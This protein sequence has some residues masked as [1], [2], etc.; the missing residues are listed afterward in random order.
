MYK[1]TIVFVLLI[2]FCVT[3][4]VSAQGNDSTQVYLQKAGKALFDK[5]YQ[6]ALTNYQNVL[7]FTP[8]HFE[9]I[10]NLGI[11]YSA[12]GD[13][14]KAREYFERAYQMDESD[15]FV[16]NNLGVLYSNE[17]NINKA[18]EYYE[19]AVSLLPNN[20]LY[21][22]NYAQ[23][24]TKIGQNGKAIELLLKA[25]SLS[26]DNLVTLF[27]L[28]NAYASSK[29]YSRA[30]F[31][32]EKSLT[33]GL[34]S[35]KLYYFLATVKRNLGKENETEAYLLKTIELDSE[36]TNALIGLGFLYMHQKK[37]SKAV[38][39]FDRVLSIDPN[40]INAKI[41]KGVALQMLKDFEKSDAVLKELFAID[42][43]YGFKMLEIIRLQHSQKEK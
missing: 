16:N 9:T 35:I 39:I 23:E 22:N 33:A 8:N 18:L 2:L 28:G 41:S 34:K 40:L 12:T 43:S 20:P 38:E 27:T 6:I 26:P 21:L 37:H 25:D 15:H 32:Y 10:K 14:Q 1:R 11:I 30:E 29:N 36:H 7:R 24:F 19:K 5:K 3:L 42:S 17:G 13:Q 4:G 31:Y